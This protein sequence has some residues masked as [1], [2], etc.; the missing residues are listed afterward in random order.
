MSA[1]CTLKSQKPQSSLY[2]VPRSQYFVAVN[3]L[4][5]RAWEKAVQQ[6]SNDLLTIEDEAMFHFGHIIGNDGGEE[7]KTA[8]FGSFN[9]W[10][11]ANSRA[12]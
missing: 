11:I 7:E 10:D 8:S 12:I 5:V 3:R 9:C 4:T 1:G 2:L 6:L